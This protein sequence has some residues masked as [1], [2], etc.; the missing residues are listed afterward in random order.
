[1]ARYHWDGSVGYEEGDFLMVVDSN[2]GFNKTNAVVDTRLSY[3]VDLTDLASPFSTLTVTHHNASATAECVQWGAQR[4]EGQEDY[5]IDACY[6][7]YM[8]VYVP[9]GAELLAATPQRIPN[10]WILTKR[11]VP[12]RVDVLEEELQGLQA[13]GT[14]KVV[15]GGESL[16]TTLQFRLPGQVLLRE[17]DRIRYRL[18]IRK[19]PG[20][21][22]NPI[23]IRI[24]VSN[25]SM[26]ESVSPQA[27]IEGDH[28]LIE[29]DLRTDLDLN[30]DFRQK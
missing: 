17:G 16:T 11:G 15:P 10:G 8:R 28:I 20:T 23:V 25:R 7:N 21:I 5:P 13:F 22:A 9:F 6:W 18:Q 29:T 24:H 19:Q 14:L 4:V 1:M 26:I 12:A 30:V 27:V 2:L 3:D